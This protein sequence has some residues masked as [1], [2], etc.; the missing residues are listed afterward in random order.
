MLDWVNLEPSGE[1]DL[2]SAFAKCC[3]ERL[4]VAVGVRVSCSLGWYML[5]NVPLLSEV[6][7]IL[8]RLTWRPLIT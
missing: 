4:T 8:F 2:E 7:G 3:S 5:N 1:L 6:L